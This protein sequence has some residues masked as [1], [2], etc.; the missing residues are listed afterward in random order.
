MVEVQI[1]GVAYTLGL[2]LT[3]ICAQMILNKYSNFVEKV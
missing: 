2:D 3:Y 1:G